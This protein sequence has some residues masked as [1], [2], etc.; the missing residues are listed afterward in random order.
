VS[1]PPSR[2]RLYGLTVESLLPLPCSRVRISGEPDV[3]LT[4]GRAARFAGAR[5]HVFN[6][7][8]AWFR[9]AVLPD[10]TTYLGWTG[11]FE[12]LIAPDATEVVYRRLAG[13]ARESFNVYLL[14]HVLSFV[15]AA[16]GTEA[17]HSTVVLVGGEAVRFSATADTGN[18]RWARR[19]WRGASRSSPTTWRPSTRTAGGGPCTAASPASSC[20]RPPRS[21][22][23]GR[24]SGA[25]R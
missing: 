19:S 13:A 4:P 17:L 9:S 6:R 21:G 15:L 3:R 14:G 20:S 22:Y 18:R 8:G 5:R 10:G 24:R 7:P 23:S 11:L 1:A 25:R 16:R 12:F 2:Y